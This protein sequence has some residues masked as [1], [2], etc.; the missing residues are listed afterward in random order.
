LNS[1][2]DG[3]SGNYWSP[4]KGI[5]GGKNAKDNFPLSK[6]VTIKAEAVAAP[7]EQ[8]MLGETPPA[9]TGKSTPGFAGIVVLVSL[10][11]LVILKR[12]RE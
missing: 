4:N 10:I 1:Y 8:K 6:P 11:A 7:A 9:G 3:K 12:K 2:D 5:L